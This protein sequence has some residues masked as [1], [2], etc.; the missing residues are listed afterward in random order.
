[1]RRKSGRARD[2]K[3]SHKSAL[4][5][6]VILFSKTNTTP[7]VSLD[8]SFTLTISDRYVAYSSFYPIDPKNR[9]K[10]SSLLSLCSFSAAFVVGE[11][12]ILAFYFDW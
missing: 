6:L 7:L 10:L 2:F 8:N 11:D 9:L 4:G 12:D 5:G 3:I 1:M